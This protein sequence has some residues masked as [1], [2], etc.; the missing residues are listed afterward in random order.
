MAEFFNN[1]S[2]ITIFAYSKVFLLW[3]YQG[4]SRLVFSAYNLW[5]FYTMNI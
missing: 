2:K 4:F 3:V 5:F 1:S